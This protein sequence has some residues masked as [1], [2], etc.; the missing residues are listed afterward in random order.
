MES[1]RRPM[2][3]GAGL[4]ACLLLAA[5]TPAVSPSF[6]G[7]DPFEEPI[8]PKGAAVEAPQS[9]A[10]G[11]LGAPEPLKGSGTVKLAVLNGNPLPASVEDAFHD[12]TGFTLEQDA[13]SSVSEISGVGADAV[14]GMG[15]NDLLAAAP[16]L[17][18][19]P[20]LDL[21]PPG[22]GVE[23]AASETAYGRDDVCVLADKGWISANKRDL[24]TGMTLLARTDVAQLLAIPDPAQSSPSALFI[25]GARA[26]F[27]EGL[28]QWALD[29]RAGGVLVAPTAE[30]E[31]SWTAI[32]GAQSGA[33][34][35][36]PL[37]V[38]PMSAITRTATGTGVEAAARA[39][40]G[41]CVQ[42]FVYAAPAAG[43]ANE[44]GAAS[45]I[46]WLLTWSGQRALAEAG[47]VYPLE[48]EALENT[49][50]HWF[51]TPSSDALVLDEA[52]I[53][54]A[55]DAVAQW[56]SARKG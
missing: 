17:G 4:A 7:V 14:I 10:E 40:E 11:S 33:E 27:G 51:L 44:E 6:E 48:P 45:F 36:R 2:R 9:A 30:A 43:A 37:L 25:A 42:R 31:S 13:V 20:A 5:C 38:G 39:V 28:G 24:P 47:A 12:Q 19:A 15:A 56:D 21:V 22:T 46:T 52:A 53:G 32:E 49:A 8:A 1:T 16:S 35:S 29:L 41:T 18:A 26:A 55:A 3:I 34:P 50:A 23:G 54:D